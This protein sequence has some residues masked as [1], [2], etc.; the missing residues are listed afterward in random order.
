MYHHETQ[1]L[2]IVLDAWT[3]IGRLQGAILCGMVMVHPVPTAK[4]AVIYLRMV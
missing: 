4:Y 1:G 3:N 2:Q